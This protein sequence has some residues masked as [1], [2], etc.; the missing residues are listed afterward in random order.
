MDRPHALDNMWFRIQ[1]VV[2]TEPALDDA[3]RHEFMAGVDAWII[4]R[5]AKRSIRRITERWL[6]QPLHLVGRARFAAD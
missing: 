3:E 6:F 1:E 5:D 4:E 2:Y